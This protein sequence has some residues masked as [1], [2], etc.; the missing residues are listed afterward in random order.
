MGEVLQIVRLQGRDAFIAE[1]AKEISG[2]KELVEALA[3]AIE[4]IKDMPV[5]DQP[6]SDM[7]DMEEMLSRFVGP[8]NDL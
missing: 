6:L 7:G 3:A 8:A 1:R 2:K 4:K 5:E